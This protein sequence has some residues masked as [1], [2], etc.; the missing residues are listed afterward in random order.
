MAINK[1]ELIFDKVRSIVFKDSSTLE[2]K[3][4]LTQIEDASLNCTAESDEVVDAMG[5]PITVFHRAKRANFSASNSLLSMDLAAAQFGTT[6]TVA[7]SGTGNTVTDYNYEIL[8]IK[9]NA[10]TPT[11]YTVPALQATPNAGSL[12]YI[13]AIENGDIGTAYA[14]GTEVS[15]TKFTLTGNQITLPTGLT[16]G[17]IYVEYAYESENAVKVT[18]YAEKFPE[19]GTAIIYCYFRDVCN[20]NTVY[21][22]KIISTRAKVNPESID[23]ALNSTG[24]HPFQIDF[25][26]DYCDE[27]GELFSIIVSQPPT[28][29]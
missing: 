17:K 15:A 27:D 24:K 19:M 22:G 3:W 18:N 1:N 7:S 23:I 2:L 21:S 11:T 28:N 12:K 5:A 26:R 6:K 9:A 8:T 20:E 13:Y 16:S 29:T 25:M 10:G 4:R 14:L